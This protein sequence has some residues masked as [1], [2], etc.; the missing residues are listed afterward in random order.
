MTKRAPTRGDKRKRQRERDAGERAKLAKQIE[1]SIMELEASSF[2]KIVNEKDT[3]ALH[4]FDTLV[5]L[6]QKPDY[7]AKVDDLRQ[8]FT[9]ENFSELLA[10]DFDDDDR[11]FA[12]YALTAV[13][14]R[15]YSGF[16]GPIRRAF[17][18]ANLNPEDPMHW[19]LLMLLL[20]WS[21]F[22]PPNPPGHPPEWNDRRCCKLLEDADKVECD[23]KR[24]DL[25]IS[26]KLRGYAE[27]SETLREALRRDPNSNGILS[28]F[29]AP[30]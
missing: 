9:K 29:F 2:L 21:V 16:D 4:R 17:A 20:C 19:R 11:L 6:L 10:N 8:S 3:T 7:L 23:G 5:P 24:S 14:L 13:K 27:K 15:P 28:F 12:L 30:P 22:P 18:K 1:T 26:K 25:A